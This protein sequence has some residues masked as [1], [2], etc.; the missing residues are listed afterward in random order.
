MKEP[1]NDILKQF[2]FAD[3]EL[4]QKALS[5]LDQMKIKPL[6]TKEEAWAMFEKSVIAKA[7][8]KPKSKVVT[9]G[10]IWKIAASLFLIVSIG[11]GF[12]TWNKTNYATTNSQ[13]REVV[14]PDNSTVTLNAA[15]TLTFNK[16]RWKSSRKVELTGEAL[17]KVTKGS[18]FEISTLGKTIKVLGTEFNV[19]S[20]TDYFAVNCISG[21]V[22]VLIPGNKQ[23]LL[24]K[25]NAVRKE[26]GSNEPIKVEEFADG[27]TWIKGEFYYKNANI[28]LVFDEIARQFNVH[29]TGEVS[30]HHY[31]GYFNKSGLTE[32]LN[33]VC[34]PL[35]LKYSISKD[36]V[37]IRKGL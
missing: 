5:E 22:E 31:T 17:F 24:T 16:F 11:I 20:R 15:T 33:N 12:K 34:L 1:E 10:V 37:I 18:S 21:R 3:D 6:K 35:G 30:D 27:T 4:L 2:G 36:T 26:T 9:F 8:E 28:N 25:G 7:E 13:R 19:F 14:L 32:A 23:I 29:I